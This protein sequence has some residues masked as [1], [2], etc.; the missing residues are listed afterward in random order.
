M[1]ECWQNLGSKCG[2]AACDLCRRFFLILHFSANT[3]HYAPN[4]LSSPTDRLPTRSVD[5]HFD[6]APPAS[7]YSLRVPRPQTL[8]AKPC[9][10]Y[11]LSRRSYAFGHFLAMKF[12]R[13]RCF[14]ILGVLRAVRSPSKTSQMAVLRTRP[15]ILRSSFVEKRRPSMA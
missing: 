2:T 3:K 11:G 10:F 1:V 12:P 14:L 4:L 7:A 5:W 8:R 15:G 9:V 6:R 13:T